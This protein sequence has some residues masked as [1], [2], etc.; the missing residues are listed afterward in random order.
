MILDEDD[1]LLWDTENSEQPKEVPKAKHKRRATLAEK[2]L[3]FYLAFS[4]SNTAMQYLLCL[5]NEEGIEVPQSVYLL[6]KK[7]ISLIK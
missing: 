2:L 1:D 7:I 3:Y 4:L 6:K 5:L